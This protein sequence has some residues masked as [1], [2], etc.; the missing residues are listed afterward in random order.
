MRVCRNKHSKVAGFRRRDFGNVNNTSAAGSMAGGASVAAASNPGDP[1]SAL[2]GLTAGGALFN[3]NSGLGGAALAPRP[4]R[5]PAA[6]A[7]R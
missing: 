2:S 4:N 1:L 6:S 3:V 7:A 5:T